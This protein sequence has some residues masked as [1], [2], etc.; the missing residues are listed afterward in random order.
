MLIN[1]AYEFLNKQLERKKIKKIIKSKKNEFPFQTLRNKSRVIV[2]S[3]FY[4]NFNLDF[5]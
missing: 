5:E 4:L 2:N 1:E 3:K